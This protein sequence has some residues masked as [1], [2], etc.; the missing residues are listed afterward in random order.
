[1][2]GKG[3]AHSAA[4]DNL[5]RLGKPPEVEPSTIPKSPAQK[6]L[7]TA[8]ENDP[9]KPP[10]TETPPAPKPDDPPKPPDD[11]IP[12]PGE[13]PAAKQKKPVDFLR[14]KLTATETERNTFKTENE[15]LKAEATKENPDIRKLTE[16]LETERKARQELETEMRFTNY[17]RSPEYKEKYQQPYDEAWNSGRELVAKLKFTDAEGNAQPATAQ[18]FDELMKLYFSDPDKAAET[19]ASLFGAKAA[20]ITP[21]MAEVAKAARAA[22]TAIETY[23]KNGSEREKQRAE[24]STNFLKAVHSEWSERQK[25]D[26]IPDKYKPLLTAKE[27]DDEGNRLLENGYKKFDEVM[28]QD[29]RT[30]GLSK[31]KRQEILDATAAQRHL[32]ANARRLMKWNEVK[33]AKIAELEKALADY[34]KSEPGAGEGKGEK[35]E[36]QGSAMDAAFRNL[37][38]KAKPQTFF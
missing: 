18:H 29:A 25:P 37:D 36:P 5:E 33:D 34:G 32:A 21:Q 28:R 16:Q 13:Q 20:F 1:M 14:E 4:F 3:A 26:L 35:T 12:K 17:E 7:D 38:K 8:K 30:P 24:F 10:K 2:Q 9:T 22:Q 6:A 19:V 23:R 31:E 11:A 27:G 15:R